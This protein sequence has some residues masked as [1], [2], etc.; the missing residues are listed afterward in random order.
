MDIREGPV[1]RAAQERTRVQK[2]IV[3]E[4]DGKKSTRMEL[5]TGYQGGN[6]KE[7]IIRNYNG[8]RLYICTK[9]EAAVDG[10]NATV[11]NLEDFFCPGSQ[12]KKLLRLEKGCFHSVCNK[13]W[14]SRQVFKQ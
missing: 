3:M 4:A 2:R 1:K 7:W 12:N 9:K 6:G 14:L 11:L 10:C 8:G 5:A 13:Q